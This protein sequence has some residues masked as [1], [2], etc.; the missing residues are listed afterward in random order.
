MLLFKFSSVDSLNASTMNGSGRL[1]AYTLTKLLNS[2]SHKVLTLV[3]GHVLNLFFELLDF[4]E[5]LGDGDADTYID[6]EVSYW[7]INTS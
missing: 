7:F 3:D 4:C 2:Q 6:M 1:H 5:P